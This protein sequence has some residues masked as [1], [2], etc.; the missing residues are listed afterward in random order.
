M[1]KFNTK[2]FKKSVIS[3][4]VVSSVASVAASPIPVSAYSSNA[5]GTLNSM[6]SADRAIFNQIVGGNTG[7][8]INASAGSISTSIEGRNS[9]NGYQWTSWYDASN[10]NFNINKSQTNGNYQVGTPTKGGSTIN[11]NL[12]KA[13]YYKYLRDPIYSQIKLKANQTFNW[14]TK[15]TYTVSNS[16]KKYA[17]IVRRGG[18]K[19][20]AYY[21]CINDAY[22]YGIINKSQKSSI[23]RL[24]EKMSN[25]QKDAQSSCQG[26][27]QS[28]APIAPDKSYIQPGTY[29][30]TKVI[31]ESANRKVIETREYYGGS[32]RLSFPKCRPPYSNT[33]TLVYT[34]KVT[35]TVIQNHSAT[36]QIAD[37]VVAENASATELSKYKTF[38]LKRKTNGTGPV[39]T[40]VAKTNSGWWGANR[41]AYHQGNSTTRDSGGTYYYWSNNTGGSRSI[42]LRNSI[43][44]KEKLFT[45]AGVPQNPGIDN[46]YTLTINPNG[47]TYNGSPSLTQVKQMKGST[48]TV[49]EPSRDQYVLG[50]W[51]FSGGGS[52]NP[53]TR[54]YQFGT[55]DG[56]LTA[57]WVSLDDIPGL[58]DNKDK[59]D[60]KDPD[61]K[62][63]KYTLTI[64]PNGGK[65]K[66]KTS[67]TTV[68]KKI[69]E[70]EAIKNPTRTGYIFV[71]WDVVNG[72]PNCFSQGTSSSMYKFYGDATLKAKWIK[73]GTE[74]TGTVIIDPNGGNYNGSTDKVTISG[75]TGDTTTIKTPTRE[76]HFFK[77]WEVINL[78]KN[79]FN[80]SSFTFIEGTTI[81]KA[82]WEKVVV[83][84][85]IVD[86]TG[87]NTCPTD[88]AM[89]GTWVH[90]TKNLKK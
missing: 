72:N 90:L 85:C 87:P 50:G 68:T 36:V 55:G 63:L 76:D 48:Y 13:G 77:G 79:K 53:N 26:T 56:S 62:H 33:A 66:G 84:P 71:G 89:P 35:H 67:K 54:K 14:V 83:P 61:I 8:I 80:G 78:E 43:S 28:S 46:K 30:T 38:T 37:T 18:F 11:A 6:S 20:K 44:Q 19:K 32:L 29:K 12:T 7:N 41:P 81:L 2:S 22:K 47:G 75:N 31:E 69:G 27:S 49:N 51:D 86:G 3:L 5:S 25:A 34:E 39:N 42:N 9:V 52:W 40:T 24:I 82:K 4:L 60:P 16:T 21:E 58:P 88:V 65:Y 1:L 17:N 59:V 74:N 64:D 45:F 23:N 73:K 57:K 70:T 15:D 10:K